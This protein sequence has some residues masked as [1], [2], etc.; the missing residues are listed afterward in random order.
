MENIIEERLERI[1]KMLLSQKNVLTFPEAAAYMGIS[2]SHLYKMTM[3][4]SISYFK[5][6]GKMIYFERE[7]L[8]N[9]LLQN[10]IAPVDE[11]EAKASTYVA[12]NKG[13]A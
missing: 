6:R 7:S 9:E 5:P 11:I 2:H 8:E 4:N 13:R 3:N 10:R 12:L 1:E